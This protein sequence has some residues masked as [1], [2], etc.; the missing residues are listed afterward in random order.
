MADVVT[1]VSPTEKWDS[2]QV[3]TWHPPH[4]FQTTGPSSAEETGLQPRR[5]RLALLLVS[6]KGR[7]RT[8]RHS[9]TQRFSP[10]VPLLG[11]C[12]GQKPKRRETWSWK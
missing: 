8:C 9:Q 2:E 6:Q 11:T 7:A 5:E 10:H 4:R 3:W 12:D 1:P